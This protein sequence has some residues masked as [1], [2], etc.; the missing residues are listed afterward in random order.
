MQNNPRHI[1]FQ[2]DWY[3]RETHMG[4]AEYARQAGWVLESGAHTQ[5]L[6]SNYDGDGIIVMAGGRVQTRELLDSFSGPAVNL[7]ASPTCT[8]PRVT[9]DDAASGILAA[10]YFLAR[11]FQNLAVIHCWGEDH[12]WALRYRG[13]RLCNASAKTD[14]SQSNSL[15][16]QPKRQKNR[17]AF[18]AKL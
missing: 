15:I 17:S 11:H 9:H 4:I 16:S 7:S 8:L 18:S 5:W 3:V 1:L 13:K 6:I 10:N 12:S 14:S 2:A